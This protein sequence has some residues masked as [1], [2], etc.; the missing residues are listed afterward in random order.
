MYKTPDET[1]LYNFK[2]S[3]IDLITYEVKLGY[4]VRAVILSEQLIEKIELI[5]GNR[6]DNINGFVI[7]SLDSQITPHEY[8]GMNEDDLDNFVGLRSDPLH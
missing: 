7:E 6:P 4:K 8:A 1:W 3:V 2:N 5:T